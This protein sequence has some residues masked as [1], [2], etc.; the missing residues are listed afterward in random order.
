LS[1]IPIAFAASF[2]LAGCFGNPQGLPVNISICSAAP[3]ERGFDLVALVHNRATK[4]MSR[5]DV[6]AAFYQ[7]FRYRDFSATAFL[8]NELD[9]GE[10]RRVTFVVFHTVKQPP[11]GQAI[12]CYATHVGYLD[13][14]SEDAPPSQ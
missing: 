9:P 5:I 8:K 1:R 7:D 3:D 6:T 2:A 11:K 14:T 13:G 12:R 10:A 4:P